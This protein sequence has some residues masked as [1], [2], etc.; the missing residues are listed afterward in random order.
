MIGFQHI[1]RVSLSW[2]WKAP[3]LTPWGAESFIYVHSYPA[4]F[5]AMKWTGIFE[6]QG[7]FDLHF[8]SRRPNKWN[9]VSHFIIETGIDL[10]SALF[11]VLLLKS[12][13]K[14]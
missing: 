5:S 11:V 12:L 14:S 8:Y 13:L 1:R 6:S 4:H 2:E 10:S 7:T 3:R 9:L